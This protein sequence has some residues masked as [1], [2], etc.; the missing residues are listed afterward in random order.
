MRLAFAFGS[1]VHRAFCRAV[2]T[3]FVR[4]FLV[5]VLVSLVLMGLLPLV[6]SRRPIGP[7]SLE[8]ELKVLAVGFSVAIIA[9]FSGLV[10][11]LGG[12][13]RVPLQR[14]TPLTPTDQLVLLLAPTLCLTVLPV[15]TLGTP[16]VLLGA[17][18]SE[19]L[20]AALA[21]AW[22]SAGGWAIGGS[23]GSAV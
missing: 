20:A 7:P 3:R 4:W 19:S 18:V 8:V 14:E 6:W 23:L 5:L 12:T 15:I 21:G 1:E 17:E 2:P 16:M 10:H 11:V 13:E 22:L 9:A